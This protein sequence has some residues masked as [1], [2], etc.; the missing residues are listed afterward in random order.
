V[1]WSEKVLSVRVFAGVALLTARRPA[2][3]VLWLLQSASLLLEQRVR[4]AVLPFS[5]LAH[6]P[7]VCVQLGGTTKILVV[8]PGSA[9]TY[10][11]CAFSSPNVCLDWTTQAVGQQHTSPCVCPKTSVRQLAKR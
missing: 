1:K 9:R 2:A 3:V 11:L 4:L 6:Q 8:P 5:C 7:F 10:L